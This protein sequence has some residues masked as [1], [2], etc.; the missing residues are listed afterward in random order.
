[1]VILGLVTPTL[2]VMAQIG[3]QIDQ[4]LP[5]EAV[6]VVGQTVT[7]LGSMDTGNGKFE[8]YFGTVRVATGMA[9]GSSITASFKIPENPA[10]AYTIVLRDVTLNSNATKD[11][12]LNAAY[13]VVPAV[14]AAPQQLQEGSSVA[15]NVT[16]TGGQPSSSYVANITVTVPA[17]LSTNYSR[18]VTLPTSSQKG[19][20]TI[21]I[22][23]PDSAFEPSGSLTD[24]AGSY[25]VHFNLTQSL[26]SNQFSVG[27]VNLTQYHRGQT[28]RIRAIGYQPNETATV[29]IKNQESGA[30]MHTVD[31]A[32]A[33]TGIVAAEWAVPSNAAIGNYAITITA[34]NTPKLVPDSQI[35]TVPGYPVKIRVWDLSENPVPQI[36]VDALDTATNK[37]Y[38]GTSGAD[39]NLTLNLESGQHV[40]TAFWNDLK[41]GE[42]SITV[43]GDG[44]FSLSCG[45]TSIRVTVQDRNGLLIP[46]VALDISYQYLTTKNQQ[47]R[48]GSVTGQTD[49]SGTYTLDSTPPGITYV[50]TASVYGAVFNGGNDTV[51]NL[52][53]KP[54]SDVTIL[55]P[56]RTLTFKIID[57][58][59]NPISNARLALL[60]V[61]AGIFFGASTGSDGSAAVEATFGRYRAQVYAGSML[62]NETQVD[63]FTDKE[64][65]IECVLYNLEVNVE[66]VDYFGQPILG[67]NVRLVESDG[68]VHVE[69]TQTGGKAVFSGVVGGDMQ[70]VAYFAEGD[71]YYEARNIHVESPTTI[72]VRMGRYVALGMFLVQTSLF[73]TL[74]L[75]LAVV[76]V[77]VVVEVYRRRKTKHRKVDKVVGKVGSK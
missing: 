41:V 34:Q 70:I 48:T 68:A 28:V 17:P 9:A 35:I 52:P 65:E 27:F 6:G 26:G 20:T 23:Y 18:I 39:G 73:M 8:V 13:S 43:A 67:A 38:S 76:V 57:Y 1:M 4:V 66:V 56:A 37:V 46:S 44:E 24:Y 51:S 33:S 64:V 14:P 29:T 15:L 58:N 7:V 32:P 55:C 62:L 74:M 63:V 42:T 45:L 75:V 72:E 77:F 47:Q 54:V 61:T 71:D 19:T 59:R 36:V 30:T 10:G 49:A 5:T 25:K 2:P 3:T 40:L 22:N 31:V 11:F 21:Q 50:I 12:T 60:E 53:V 16:V 69:K